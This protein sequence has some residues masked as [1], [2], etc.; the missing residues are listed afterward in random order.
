MKNILLLIL[1]VT[2]FLIFISCEDSTTN[3]TPTPTKKGGIII[4]S[5][6]A[7]ASISY[8]TNGGISFTTT[9]KVTPDTLKDLTAGN[10]SIKLTLT[11]YKDTVLIPIS[12]DSTYK[13]VSVTLTSNLIEVTFTNIQL[14]KQAASGFSGLR[15]VDGTPVNSGG[16]EADIFFELNDVKSQDQ[17]TPSVTTPNV[18]WFLN[19]P[20]STNLQ[21]GVSSPTFSTATWGKTKAKTETSY[22]FLYTKTGN[23]VKFKISSFGGNTGP[24]DPDEW[25]KVSYRYNKT[26]G[27]TRFGTN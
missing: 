11:N 9:A 1:T 15:L 14:F 12:I 20:T 21:D 26:A 23:Y 24:S 6:P 4:T 17:R 2:F 19:S 3:P 7:G 22:S 18:T 10:Y 8:S 13:S 27:D 25:V 16:T 5:T